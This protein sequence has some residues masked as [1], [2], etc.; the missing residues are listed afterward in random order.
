MASRRPHVA[1][2][3]MTGGLLF[4]ILC[5]AQASAKLI[6]MPEGL[7]FALHMPALWVSGLLFQGERA[8]LGMPVA[9]LAQWLLL[10][11]VVGF[12]IA[13]SRKSNKPASSD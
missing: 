10:G 3:T 12:I 9:I 8:L 11:W 1:V 2:F 7:F 4:G 13:R 5:L 6:W